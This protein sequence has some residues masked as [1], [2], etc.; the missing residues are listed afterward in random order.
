MS[1]FYQILNDSILIHLKV[2]PNSS[3]NQ[4]IGVLSDGKGGA[5][6]KVKVTAI[7]ES[8]KAN[9]AIIK[10]LS[11]FWKI[12]SSKISVNSGKTSSIKT[13]SIDSNS[14]EIIKL[15]SQIK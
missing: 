7:P 10:F 13:I 4:I 12:P 2:I 5:Y 3:K 15:L 8:G 6:L 1:G 14:N 9:K 11:K